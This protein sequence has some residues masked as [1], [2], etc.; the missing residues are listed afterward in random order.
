M[1]MTSLNAIVV[2]FYLTSA[3]FYFAYLLLQKEYLYQTGYYLLM[4]GFCGHSAAV[5]FEFIEAGHIPV[6]NLHETLIFVGWAIAGVF[7]VIQYRFKLR[8]LGVFTAPLIALVMLVA[9]V[10]PQTQPA[11][12]K[13][14]YSF[15]LNFHILSSFMANASFSM[16]CGAGILYLLQE[17]AIK[18]KSRGFFFKRLPSLQLLDTTGYG[19]IIAGFTLLTIGLITGLIYAKTVWGKFW[20]WD[21]KEVWSAITWLVYAALLHERLTVGWR[22]RKAAILAIIGF[23]VLLFTFFG[24]NFLLKGHHGAFTQF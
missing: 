13:L 9:Y 6:R 23:S 11:A 3:G 10:V 2:L 7:L 14:F 24:V 19:C 18:N 21:P 1:S 22:G 15:W 12:N 20:N 5:V 8:I 4:A 17:R 16:A